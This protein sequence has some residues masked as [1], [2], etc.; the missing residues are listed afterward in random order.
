MAQILKDE[1]RSR[2]ITISK[3][4][5][6][7][8]KECHQLTESTPKM[9]RS[10]TRSLNRTKLNMKGLKRAAKFLITETIKLMTSPK[11]EI[12]FLRETLSME[13][14]TEKIIWL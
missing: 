3:S 5:V 14:E 9:Q 12:S 1:S 8:T 11:S 13:S 4:E 10:E 2:V 7:S 6:S